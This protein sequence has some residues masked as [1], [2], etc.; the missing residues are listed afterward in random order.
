MAGSKDMSVRVYALDKILHFKKFLLG[1]NTDAIVGCFFERDSMDAYTVAKNGTVS[2]W[3]FSEDIE[4][5]IK[6]EGIY[7]QISNL[8]NFQ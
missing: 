2:T 8:N 7:N 4:N 6:V 5:L 1:G 3:E